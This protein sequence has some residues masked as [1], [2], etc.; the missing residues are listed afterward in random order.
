M[1]GKFICDAIFSREGLT[2]NLPWLRARSLEV[3]N[4]RSETKGFQF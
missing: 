2:E 3:S 1:P 4:L